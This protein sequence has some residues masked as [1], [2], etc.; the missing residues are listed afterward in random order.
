MEVRRVDPSDASIFAELNYQLI[1]DEGHRSRMTV[2]ELEGRMR[3]W[4]DGGEYKAHVF[5]SDSSIIGYTLYREEDE[6]IYIRQFFVRP[7]F[8]RQ[9]HGRRAFEWLAQHVWHDRRLS[10]DVLVENHSGIAF[11]RSMGFRDYCITMEMAGET[12]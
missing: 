9:G 6:A 11:W 7:D 8:R 5:Q 10:L 1:R 4:L 12:T 3:A 2:S